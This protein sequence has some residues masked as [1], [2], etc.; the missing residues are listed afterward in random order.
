MELPKSYFRYFNGVYGYWYFKLLKCLGSLNESS[1][2]QT[3]LMQSKKTEAYGLVTLKT[4]NCSGDLWKLHLLEAPQVSELK[5][6]P[7]HNQLC[8]YSE[9]FNAAY[10]EQLCPQGMRLTT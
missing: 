10:A 4:I 6:Q 3:V 8:I 5:T 7:L 1:L 9:T 2:T